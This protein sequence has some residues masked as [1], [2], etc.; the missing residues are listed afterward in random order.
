MHTEPNSTELSRVENVMSQEETLQIA[1]FMIWMRCL[2][3]ES[4]I[5]EASSAEEGSVCL[6]HSVKSHLQLC[7]YVI[8]I[9]LPKNQ[10]SMK[11]AHQ[12]H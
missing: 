1:K 10:I 12:Q 8:I 2:E 11:L 9:C 5:S 7:T 4:N 6:I 3:L